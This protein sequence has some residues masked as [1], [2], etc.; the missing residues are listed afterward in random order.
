[1]LRFI[2]HYAKNPLKFFIDPQISGTISSFPL[3][4]SSLKTAFS[5]LLSRYE[6]S[7]ISIEKQWYI[8]PKTEVWR[9]VP[10]QKLVSSPISLL[11]VLDELAAIGQISI[12]FDRVQTKQKR[13]QRNL[14]FPSV[15][16]AIQD[17]A[18]QFDWLVKYDSEFHTLKLVEEGLLHTESL[19]LKNIGEKQVRHF[20]EEAI[21]LVQALKQLELFFPSD[22]ILMVKGQ[23]REIE[24]VFSAV[25]K[26]DLAHS[27]VPDFVDFRFETILLK[28]AS[29]EKIKSHLQA[30]FAKDK[31]LARDMTIKWQEEEE[32]GKSRS[33]VSLYGEEIKIKKLASII[34]KL[35]QTYDLPRPLVV[36]K[37]DL[38]YLHVK[39]KKIISGGEE[40]LVE[41]VETK[42]HQFLQKL[43][44][45]EKD[46]LAGSFQIIPEFI[47][48]SVVIKGTAE[49]VEVAKKILKVWDK[50][51]PVIR[52]EAHIFETSDIVSRELGLQFSARGIPE[53]GDAV[54]IEAAGAYTAGAVLGPLQTTKAF[55]V[56]TLLR[57]MESEGKGRVLSRPL[58]VT[59]NNIEAE[60]RS[61]DIINVKVV[62]DNQPTLKE[63]KTGV[64]LRVTPRLIKESNG[65]S[66]EYKIRLNVF[67][68]SSTPINETVD[69]IPRINSQ[70]ARSEVV[71]GNGEPFLLGGLIRSNAS[72]SDSG[73]PLLKDIPIFG[74]LFKVETLSD[75][76]NHIL[77]FVTPS[78]I[79]PDQKQTLPDASELKKDPLI[80][81]FQ[82]L[83][84]KN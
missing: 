27:S 71:V 48:N 26:F 36:E 68:E 9:R 4:S 75:R 44:K 42:L 51:Q 5:W 57:L 80:R 72:E 2:N 24:T 38:K 15:E 6:L 7:A 32:N 47:G 56:D 37:V 17:L 54:N 63:I 66:E 83:I 62:I 39:S 14:I 67:A 29:P 79:L 69:N 61:G 12:G 43:V 81:S 50:P 20:F 60:M 59:M 52:I 25:E 28:S 8:L 22:Q 82:Q 53:G 46:S 31:L 19:L 74:Y 70:T 35:D 41:G 30:I 76:F 49:E 10:Y 11:Q 84:E 3:A 16:A 13:I 65:E 78:V 34:S 73:V 40:I 23:K 18:N 58:V 1:M 45:S 21:P 77:V 64:I 33:V 55:Q